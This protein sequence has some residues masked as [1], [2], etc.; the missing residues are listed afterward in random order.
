MNNTRQ[1]NNVRK[2]RR[3]L[4]MTQQQLA[5]LIGSGK[6]YICE[7][8]SGLIRNPSLGKARL[9]SINLNSQLDEVFPQ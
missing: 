6:G 2:I 9:I 3:S 8:E 4:D 5:D 1:S 7:L